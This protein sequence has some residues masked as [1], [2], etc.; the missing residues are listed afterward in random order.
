MPRHIPMPAA[1][2]ATILVAAAA[3]PAAEFSA[4]VRRTSYGYPHIKAADEKGLGYGAGYAFAQDNFCLLAEDVTTVNGERSKYFGPDGTFDSSGGGGFVPNLVGD[5]HYRIVNEPALVEVAWAKQPTEIKHLARGY[6]AGVNRWLRDTGVANLPEACRNAPWVRPVTELDL[7]RSMRRFA[8]AGGLENFILGLYSAQPPANAAAA[9]RP[10][11]KPA[12]PGWWKQFLKRD[13]KS[14]GSNVVALGRESTAS[15]KGMLLGNPH[16]PW[17]TAYRFYQQH[18]TIPGK[19]DA[20]GA[21]LSGGFPVVNIGHNG[22]VAWSHTVNT[23]AHFTLFQVTL[24]RRDPTRY[25][26][27]GVSRPMTFRDLTVDVG[28]GQTVTRRYWFTDQ[29]PLVVLP[30]LL[31][32]TGRTAYALR[33]ANFENDRL[34]EQWWAFN[35]ARSLAEFRGAVEGV[36]GVPWV[37]SV[38]VDREGTAYYGDVTVVP[39]VT[40]E[41]QA[42]CV[43]G[44]F[45]P[46]VAEGLMILDGSTAACQWETVPGTPQPGIFAAS[47]LPSMTRTDWVQNSNDSAWLTNPAQPLTGFPDI[48]SIAGTEQGGRTRYGLSMIRS[49]L[50]ALDGLPGRKF[51]L[52]QLQQLSFANRSL[53]ANVLLADLRAVC[54]AGTTAPSGADVSAPCAVLAAW[55]GTAEVTAVGWPLFDAWRGQMNA[56]GVNYWRV[57]FLAAAPAATPRGLKKDD[58]AVAGAAREALAQA[59]ASLAVAGLDIG[60]AWGSQQIALRGNERIPMHGGNGADIYNAIYNDPIG[61]GLLNVA[62]GSSTVITV[63]FET[64]PPIA[65]GWLTYSQ[66]TNPASPHFADQTRKFSRKEWISFPYSDAQ[67]QADPNYSTQMIFE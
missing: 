53:Y 32:W 43:P 37:H 12:A 40:A 48:V 60:L 23:S 52:A 18:L 24:D 49:R 33:D 44:L 66:S 35:K 11:Y 4:E 22:A 54:A 39:R 62:Y 59:A 61:D 17:T 27:D 56:A 21:S 7:I 3:A 2:A 13:G 51:T 20:L 15:G 45:R 38:A 29:G 8:G 16:F 36:L 30:G 50:A 67:I 41:R 31:E 5:F 65:Q 63:S 57:P 26:V 55:D 58:P 19:V 34:F 42:A 46:L 25:V 28:G 47:E 64:D 9:D 6:A 10:A 14:L 1:L